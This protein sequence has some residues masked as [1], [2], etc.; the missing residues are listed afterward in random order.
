LLAAATY[1]TLDEALQ[2]ILDPS[3]Q[4]IDDRILKKD[5]LTEIPPLEATLS[6]RYEWMKGRLVPVIKLRGVSSQNHVS[7]A[8]HEET[9]PGFMLVSASVN[10]RFNQYFSIA[11]G[12]NNLFDKAYYEHLN[13]SMIGSY[14]NLTEPGRSFFVNLFFKI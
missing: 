3:G 11:S 5:P 6:F 9:T 1:G 2:F 4:A 10:Y 7:Q 8:S 13:R 14:D 12:V